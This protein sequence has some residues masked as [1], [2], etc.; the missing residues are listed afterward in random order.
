MNNDC[1]YRGICKDVLDD[2]LDDMGSDYTFKNPLLSNAYCYVNFG[3]NFGPC[4]LEEPNCTVY[5]INRRIGNKLKRSRI[6][7]KKNQS[8]LLKTSL[9]GFKS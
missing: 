6:I 8:I 2:V 1:K 4:C 3:Q 5:A 9:M 7:N